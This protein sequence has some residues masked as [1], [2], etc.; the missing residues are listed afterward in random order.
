V[1][2]TI[3]WDD[4]TKIEMRVGKIL[5]V[6]DFPE[7]KKPAYLL[8]IDFGSLG[9]RKT[10]AQITNYTKSELLKREVVAVFNFP[11]KQ[12][13][14]IMSEVLVLGGVEQD[15]TVRLLKPDPSCQLGSRVG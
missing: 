7:A 15:G 5:D 11:P 13:G 1:T 4:F 3:E 8:T 12:I 9:T 10:S 14:P 2:D 6:M